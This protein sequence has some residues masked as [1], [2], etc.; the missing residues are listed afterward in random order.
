MGI[1]KSASEKMYRVLIFI[2]FSLNNVP[3]HGITKTL[4]IIH[5]SINPLD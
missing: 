4:R 5:S 1:K 2:T 3:F